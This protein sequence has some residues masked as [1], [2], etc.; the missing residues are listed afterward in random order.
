MEKRRLKILQVAP[1]LAPYAKVGGLADVAGAITKEMSRAGHDVKALCP[2]Y[3][4]LDPIKEG[5]E[6]LP[7]TFGV[8][9]GG[10]R[11]EYTQ[12]WRTIY[13][14]S[15]AEVYFIEFNRYYGGGVYEG[16]SD[17][18]ERFTFLCRAAI[19]FCH[20]FDWWPDV[21]HCHD[22]GVGLLP[23]YLNTTERQTPL[24]RAASVFT[25]HN[26]Q[27]QGRAGRELLD[28]AGLPQSLFTPD[29]LE[30]GGAVNMMKAALYHSTKLTTVS[31]HYAQEIQGPAYGC[32]LDSVLRFRSA[33]LIGILNGIDTDAWNPTTDPHIPVH[34]SAQKPAGKAVCKAEL[35]T[36]FGLEQRPEVPIFSAIARLY[37]QKGLDTF[38]EII[39]GLMNDMDLQ[40]VVLGSGDTA[41]ERWF[42]EL[43]E[44]FPKRVGVYIG[45]NN[46]RSHLIEAGSDF[47]VMPSRFEPCGLNQMYSMAY[48]TLPIVRETGG[49][50]DS[51][52][53][54]VSD[55]GEGTGFRF[56]ESSAHA[57]YYTI[58]WANAV[59][60]DQP[61]EIR[62][63]RF[64]AMSQ[65]LGW[66]QS[67][68][69]YEEVFE[70]AV[71]SRL[72]G[73]GL[74]SGLTLTP[75]KNP[76]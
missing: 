70:W 16:G 55:R 36:A 19:D 13:P 44:R 2:K 18:A 67:A 43:A 49:L 17:N 50:V 11:T 59:W 34:F 63:L 45:Y 35:Q 73:L 62:N 66:E 6:A 58:G 31:P 26:L 47:F 48:G 29:N 51:V 12:L 24:H 30:H 53:Q 25:I 52:Q 65:D 41:L 71:Q 4:M 75:W 56:H 7:T 54:Y 39:P 1:E 37:D 57:L 42:N 68:A 76:V 22:W 14:Q 72:R 20:A 8:H 46:P 28:Y 64:N 21:I 40:V 27:H 60:W 74:S 69:R 23:V 32:G 15:T 10:G 9:L 38:A 61:E 5:W 3:G 33:D